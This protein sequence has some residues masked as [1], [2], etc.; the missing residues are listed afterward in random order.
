MATRKD[1]ARSLE[2]PSG[3]DWAARE[4]ATMARDVLTAIARVTVSLEARRK[5]LADRAQP[6][7]EPHLLGLLGRLETARAVLAGSAPKRLPGAFLPETVQVALEPVRMIYTERAALAHAAARVTIEIA[8]GF[9][10]WFCTCGAETCAHALAALDAAIEF[11]R[12]PENPDRR[13]LAAALATPSWGRFLDLLD[14]ELARRMPAP[15]SEDRRLAW[16]ILLQGGAVTSIEPVL[17]KRL[18]GGR[19]S[20]GQKIS[21]AEL[22]QRSALRAHPADERAFQALA[23]PVE[24]QS[25]FSASSVNNAARAVHALGALRGHERVSLWM[26]RDV[27]ARVEVARLRVTLEPSADGYRLALVAEMPSAAGETERRPVHA[28]QLQSIDGRCEQACVVDAESALVLLIPLPPK[29][30]ALVD[31]LARQ[32]ALF[33]PESHDDLLRRL[34]QLGDSV[35]VAL[36]AELAGELVDADSRTVVRLSPLQSGGADI[37]FFV[38][39]SE[40]AAYHRPGEGQAEVLHVVRGRRVRVM[41]DL[42]AEQR[43]AL[44]VSRSLPPVRIEERAPWQIHILDEEGVLDVVVALRDRSEQVADIVVEWPDDRPEVIGVAQPSALRVRITEGRDWFGLKGDVDLGGHTI[45]LLALFDAV[46]RGQRYIALGRRRFAA[47]H[48]ELRRR[49]AAASEVMLRG[50]ANLEVAPSAAPVIASLLDEAREVV[51]GARW[52]ALR[53]RLEAA[54]EFDPP[55]PEGLTAALRPYQREGYRWLC[56]LAAW[57]MGACLADDMGLGKTLQALAFV[58]HRAKEGPAL[59]VAPTSVG[60]NWIR[61]AERFTTG[62]RVRLYR[63]ADRSAMLE[64]IGPG[65]LLVTS[66]ALAMRDAPKLAGTRFATLILDEAQAIK[67]PLTRRARALLSIGASI[68][69]ALTGTP[70]ENHLGELWSVMRMVAPGLLGSLEGFRERFAVPIERQRDSARSAAL[71]RVVRPFLLRRTKAEVA[72]ELP[73]RVEIERLV[74]LTPGER[75]LYDEAR[76]AALSALARADENE[77][78]RF[79]I[80]AALTRLRRLACN[81][82]LVVPDTTLPSSKLATFLDTVRELREGGHRAL[83]FSQFT[84]HLALVREALDREGISYMYLD[85]STSTEQRAQRVEAFQA[86]RGELFLVSLKAGGTGLNL[87]AADYVIHLD[88]WWNP[89]VEDQATDRAHRIGQTRPVSVIR[90]IARAT[91]EEAVLDLHRD[92]RVLAASLFEENAGGVAHLSTEELAALIRAG[93]RS[94]VADEEG[95]DDGDEEEASRD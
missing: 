92:K 8:D 41:R 36:P 28:R 79:T 31:A 26:G 4:L 32:P 85:G 50:R 44:E 29:A 82:R 71:A 12:D 30:R 45:S 88:P 1:L 60:P 10:R 89:A 65:D 53:A 81:P 84:T 76:R 46:R 14:K 56:R 16:R 58:L 87:T 90:L 95:P 19:W 83:V 23:A 94:I 5:L 77:N 69:I 3:S 52:K 17:Q 18:K 61:E 63:G 13:T 47:I 34:G 64:G 37:D 25:G 9:P 66:Y 22:A 11:L 74:D 15:P 72:P 39:P 24:W 70:I 6:P 80:L 55:L 62:L 43:R 21:L 73:P 49:L 42:A 33:P 93:E 27:P 68:G 7:T 2:L 40:G 48:D 86:G 59:V 51:A 57:G 91:I 38:R 35:E 67:N 75:L 20:P 54:E 78:T